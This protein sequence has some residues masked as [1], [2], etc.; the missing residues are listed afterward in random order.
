MSNTVIHNIM[1]LFI[2][3]KLLKTTAQGYIINDINDKQPFLL[4]EQ[5]W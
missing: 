1:T 4:L 3:Q 5:S 2:I